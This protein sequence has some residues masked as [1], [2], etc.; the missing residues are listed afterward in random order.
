MRATRHGADLF[1][2]VIE[3]RHGVPAVTLPQ[4]SCQEVCKRDQAAAF[5][6]AR[7]SRTPSTYTT[8]SA[9]SGKRGASSRKLCSATTSVLQMTAVAFSTFLNRLA[10]AVRSR[11]A[12]NGD[13]TTFVVCRCF[14]C[15][16]GNA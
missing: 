11:T 8:P 14:Q 1:E 10:A 3:P 6:W 4:R 13:F 12:A 7:F 16:F 2:L 5:A 9:T 15:S